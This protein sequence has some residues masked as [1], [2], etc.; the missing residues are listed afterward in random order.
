MCN[1]E[2][3]LPG[4]RNALKRQAAFE[5][6]EDPMSLFS[7]FCP[8]EEEQ[9]AQEVPSGLDCVSR[10]AGVCS[11]P[12][13]TPCSKAVVSQAL[14]DSFNGFSKVQRVCGISNNPCKW[15]K[16]HVLQWLYWAS[17]EFSLTNISFFKFDMS[18][19]ELCDLGKDGFLDL[20]PDFVGDILWEHLEQMTRACHEDD[21]ARVLSRSSEC[22]WT[23][24]SSGSLGLE[25][26]SLK[27]PES[28]SSLLRELFET[29]EESGLLAFGQ[30]LSM[31][32][33]PQLSSVSISHTSRVSSVESVDGSESVLRSWGSHSSLADA[34]RVPS[35]DSFEEELCVAP[36]GLGKQGLSFKDYV[37]ERNEP[38]EQGK[39]VIPA[40]VLA[41]FTGSGPKNRL[42]LEECSL[43]VPESCSSL[44]REL[45]E[46]SEESGLLA[47]GQELSM[48]PKPQLSSV[49]ISYTSRGYL[50]RLFLC[51]QV[52]RR[53][54]KRKNKPKMNYEKLSRGL[55]YY[56]DKNIIHKTSGKR[57]VYRFVCDL[58]NLLG[59]TVEEL[60][61]MLGVQ[62]DTED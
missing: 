10:D 3:L 62:P 56:Y 5:M 44:L 28:C 31:Y 32:P 35:Y 1:M 13:L 59:Y 24:S 27:V 33:K 58:H 36:L 8:V 18:G 14:K 55:R 51:R 23:S 15:T 47:F 40:A 53:W 46:T 57:Y 34:Q 37:Q 29:S 61:G 45:F 6:F 4:F 2:P 9:A 11:V 52:A 54:G 16:Q 50:T 39:P 22:S 12:L 48:Y 49:S 20:A 17:G 41:G 7:G 26:C 30:E 38:L 42:G 19:Q 25:E 60:H 43:K 21:E